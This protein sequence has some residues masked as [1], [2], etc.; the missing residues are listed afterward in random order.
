MAIRA[1]NRHI[2]QTSKRNSGNT[3]PTFKEPLYRCDRSSVG[4]C[5]LHSSTRSM[6]IPYILNIKGQ[7]YYPALKISWSVCVLGGKG[8]NALGWPGLKSL[9]LIEIPVDT[10]ANKLATMCMILRK[11]RWSH[12]QFSTPFI[13]LMYWQP[14]VLQYVPIQVSV[15]R[16][17]LR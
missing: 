14:F 11:Q 12:N 2:V 3:F 13:W 10:V 8:C 1:P 16:C 5:D 17:K 6:E 15:L 4:L 9:H 7:W